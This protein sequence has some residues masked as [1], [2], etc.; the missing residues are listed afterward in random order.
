MCVCI[1]HSLILLEAFHC[2]PY[3]PPILPPLLLKSK[4]FFHPIT[5]FTHKARTGAARP[6]CWSSELTPPPPTERPLTHPYLMNSLKSSW[7]YPASLQTQLMIP[8]S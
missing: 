4:L 3:P 2:P 8:L 6:R 5:G 1:A 7:D